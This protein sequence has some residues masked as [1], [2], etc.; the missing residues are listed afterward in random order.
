MC[1]HACVYGVHVRVCKLHNY[2]HSLH[3]ITCIGD[4]DPMPDDKAGAPSPTS[5]TAT[6]ISDA[7]KTDVTT[8]QGL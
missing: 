4:D 2:L 8:I 1:V 7:A 3:R 6:A 5:A